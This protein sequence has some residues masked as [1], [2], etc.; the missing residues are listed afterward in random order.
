[1]R[2]F[3][4][5]DKSFGNYMVDADGNKMLDVYTQVWSKRNN[6]V[7]KWNERI[8]MLKFLVL[9][10]LKVNNFLSIEQLKL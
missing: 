7:L 5:F 3:V 6:L 4:D 8:Y 9:S 2:A 1:M 10:N